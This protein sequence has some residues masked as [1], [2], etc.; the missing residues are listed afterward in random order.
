MADTVLIDRSFGETRLAFLT[1]DQLTDLYLYRDEDPDLTG[2][3]HRARVRRVAPALDG[4]FLDLGNGHEA[5]LKTRNPP[6]EG[7]LVTVEIRAEGGT[8][9]LPIASLT[10]TRT[11]PDTLPDHPAR[12]DQDAW[13]WLRHLGDQPIITAA[14][15]IAQ[16]LRAEGR[17]VTLQHADP[18]RELGL[19]DD[20]DSLISAEVPFG[21][22][23]RLWIEDTRALTAIDIDSGSAGEGRASLAT[24]RAV[25]DR[26]VSEIARQ[27]RLRRLGGLI[28]IDFLRLPDKAARLILTERLTAALKP[29]PIPSEII[30]FSRAGLFELKRP[31]LGRPLARDLGTQGKPTV[32]TAA[33][34]ALRA[35][36]VNARPGQ[37]LTLTCAPA[38]ADWIAAHDMATVFAKDSGAHMTVLADPALTLGRFSV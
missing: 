23:A 32:A 18:F 17:A 27:L 26:A 36:R 3:V 35:A 11:V 16:I 21:N 33:R 6:S 13:P 4:A 1:D 7:S 12:L 8:G 10:I 15:D 25:N 14:P 9:K 22:G 30:G 38:V 29:D 31:R 20:I 2:T 34:Q 19:D 24:A 37:P 28:I 5:F